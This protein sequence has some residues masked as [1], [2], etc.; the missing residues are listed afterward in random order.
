MEVPQEHKLFFSP[1]FLF[2]IPSNLKHCLKHRAREPSRYWMSKFPCKNANNVCSIVFVHL[3]IH[4]AENTSFCFPQHLTQG[5]LVSIDIYEY[6]CIW[7]GAHHYIIEASF[8]SFLV[9]SRGV[10]GLKRKDAS[11][12]F[13]LALCPCTVALGHFFSPNILLNLQKSTKRIPR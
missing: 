11:S 7:I 13:R 2:T 12:S 9:D 10:T 4:N 8:S 1:L 6:G 5:F 3:I